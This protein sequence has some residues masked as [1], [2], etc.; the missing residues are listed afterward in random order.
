MATILGLNTATRVVDG[1]YFCCLFFS[2]RLE[3]IEYYC[4]TVK[5]D[6]ML[7]STLFGII[8]YVFMG[9][10]PYWVSFEEVYR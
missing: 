3:V 2:F 10:F 8:V 1:D 6:N 5:E 4:T 9:I 7:R